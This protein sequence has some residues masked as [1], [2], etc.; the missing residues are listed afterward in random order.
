MLSADDG[1][2][3]PAYDAVI[4]TVQGRDPHDDPTRK[5][6][7]PLSMDRRHGPFEIQGT[8]FLPATQWFSFGTFTTNT[9]IIPGISNTT[10]F[11]VR[12]QYPSAPV[13]ADNHIRDSFPRHRN[14]WTRLAGWTIELESAKSRPHDNAMAQN[15]SARASRDF[16]ERGW[17]GRRRWLEAMVNELP[18]T[19]VKRSHVEEIATGQHSYKVTQLAP[20]TAGIAARRWDAALRAR[21]PCSRSGNPT[22]RFAWKMWARTDVVNLA[23]QWT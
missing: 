19:D 21:G 23:V 10:F 7:Y 3:T 14:S 5:H 2:H 12:G 15:H 9:A 18:P 20:W 1:I 17:D 22:D 4:I 16:D 8:P 6:E 11:R 13:L